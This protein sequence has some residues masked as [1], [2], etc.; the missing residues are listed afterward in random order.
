MGKNNTP[1]SAP[2]INTA[3]AQEPEINEVDGEPIIH[4]DEEAGDDE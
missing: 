2:E 3:P 1:A 4:A